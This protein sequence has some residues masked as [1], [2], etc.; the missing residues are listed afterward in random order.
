MSMSHSQAGDWS[1]GSIGAQVR[2]GGSEDEGKDGQR[3]GEPRE[4]AESD[5][6][7]RRHEEGFLPCERQVPTEV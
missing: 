6:G 7:G 5:A 4:V 3:Q 1:H 2:Q